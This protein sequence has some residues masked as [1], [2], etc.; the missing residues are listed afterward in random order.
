MMAVAEFILIL[1]VI[2]MLALIR[3]SRLKE[4]WIRLREVAEWSRYSSL[5]AAINRVEKSPEPESI[6]N[7]HSCLKAIVDGGDG[8]QIRYNSARLVE[9]EKIEEFATRVT[10]VG[11]ATS[12]VSAFFHLFFHFQWLLFFTV[13]LPSGVGIMHAINGFLRLPQLIA[14]H[15]EMLEFLHGIREKLQASTNE[16][17]A[18]ESDFPLN[19]PDLLR[20]SRSLLSRLESGEQRWSNIAIYQDL[21]PI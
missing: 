11:F 9:Y 16:T 20:T 3:R 14:H 7:L 13:L 21:H 4:Q 5:R 19:T 18:A 2:A 6:E 10:Y 8:C 1:F 17:K 15:V 12:S